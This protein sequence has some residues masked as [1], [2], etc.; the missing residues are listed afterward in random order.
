[1]QMDVTGNTG[2][3][4]ASK[5]HAE[6]HAIR[7][8]IRSKRRFDALRQPHHFAQGVWIASAEFRYV[9]VRNDHHMAGS[10]RVT[11]KNDECFRAA[12][13]D[14]G[15]GVVFAPGSVAKNAVRLDAASFMYWERQGVQ[16]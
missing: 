3:G 15:F 8:V 13:D 5:I 1:M 14:Q 10:V 4:G 11:I 2:A 12:I 9:R 6:V 16:R 7:L